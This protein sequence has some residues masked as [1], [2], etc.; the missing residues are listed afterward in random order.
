MEKHISAPS[1]NEHSSSV[2][3]ESASAVT[4]EVGS[5]LWLVLSLL[6]LYIIWGSTYFFI[7][8]A[9]ASIPPFLMTGM[10]LLVAGGV[11]YIILRLRGYAAP[12]RVECGGSARMAL[13]LIGGGMGGE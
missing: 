11:L 4:S 10:R 7:R 5:R 12:T 2:Q 9:I 13:F 6:A 8:I 3:L 1:V